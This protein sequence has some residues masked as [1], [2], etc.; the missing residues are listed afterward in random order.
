MEGAQTVDF[1]TGFDRYYDKK[2]LIMS[3][4]EKQTRDPLTSISH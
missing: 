2:D 3:E 4:K 1:Y